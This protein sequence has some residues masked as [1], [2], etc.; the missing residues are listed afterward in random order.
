[1]NEPAETEAVPQE[2]EVEQ[3]QPVDFPL[4]IDNIRIGF[5]DNG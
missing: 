2:Q 3:P 5:K 1:M 4:S